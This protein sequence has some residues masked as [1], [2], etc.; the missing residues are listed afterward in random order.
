MWVARRAAGKAGMLLMIASGLLLTT[1]VADVLPH[2]WHEAPEVGLPR[3]LVIAASILGYTVMTVFTRN[4]CGCD[5]ELAG[6]VAG[7]HAPG[8]H[9]KTKEALGAASVGVG[10]ATALTAHRVVEGSAVALDVSLPVILALVIGSASDGLALATLLQETRQRLLPWA[11]VACAS[12]AVG[13]LVTWLSPLP[14]PAIPVALALVCGVILRIAWVGLRL[15]AK[16]RASGQLP[17]WQVVTAAT[18]VTLS[19]AFMIAY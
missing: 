13:A 15:A 5:A 4:G 18:A 8:R 19:A 7:V 6:Q 17:Q 11:T 9:R 16:K 3:W 2:A 12:P 10:A 14:A 1:A